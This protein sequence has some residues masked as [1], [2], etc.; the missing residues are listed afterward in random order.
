MSFSVNTRWAI[1]VALLIAPIV[2]VLSKSL[3]NQQAD[4]LLPSFFSTDHLTAFYWD[5]K[6]YGSVHSFLAFPIQDIY[7][8]L[9]LQVLLRIA[10]FVF[11]VA[12]IYSLFKRSAYGFI[13][14]SRLGTFLLVLG[15]FL[16]LFTDT[17]E[18]LLFGAN[19]HPIAI[20]FALL[21]LSIVPVATNP[22]THLMLKRML[23]LAMIFCL[24]GIAVWTSIFIVIW[25]PA[26]L[27]LQAFAI[28]R[29]KRIPLRILGYWTAFN[30]FSAGV[31]ALIL[32]EI[33][34]RGGENTAY[35]IGTFFSEAFRKSYIGPFLITSALMMV[36][37]LILMILRRTFL[38]YIFVLVAMSITLLSVP[39]I[40]SSVHVQLYYYMPRYFGI[41]LLITILVCAMTL[42]DLLVDQ[43]SFKA[44]FPWKPR[45]SGLFIFLFFSLSSVVYL[46]SDIGYGE[47]RVDASGFVN[48]GQSLSEEIVKGIEVAIGGKPDFVAGSYWYVWPIVFEYRSRDD[49]MIAIT[50]KATRQSDFRM[51]YDGSIWNGV[52]VGETIRCW[53]ATINAKLNDF[54]LFS[55]IE[56]DVIGLLEDGTPVR[57]MQ[58][59]KY[60][61]RRLE[62]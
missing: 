47:G 12:W 40:A 51:L 38:N 17:G 45:S 53:G 16:F 57:L 5:Q 52:C 49:D 26:L 43:D 61:I 55:E 62:R 34:K 59:S 13:E 35:R 25:S 9:K 7:W 11:L 20:P 58:V 18:A 1:R 19:A 46:S 14:A 23:F 30:L 54:Q 28:N 41:P 21:A 24:W 29:E 22:S 39:V 3:D 50:K 36:L 42:F 2:A 33:A 56:A 15:G 4:N 10:S 27:S 32:S 6:R 60:P 8:N 31:W 37:I 48:T 44:Y